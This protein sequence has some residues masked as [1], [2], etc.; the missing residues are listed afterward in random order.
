MCSASAAPGA[1]TK[2]HAASSR[3]RT[4]GITSRANRRIERSASAREMVLKFTCSDA[5][6]NPPTSSLNAR[7]R[8]ASSRGV[9]IQ[10]TPFA[11]CVSKVSLASAAMIL[12]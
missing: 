2:R 8:C 12:S 1:A 4:A 3:P 9:P 10:A 7:M 5:L 6:S 11:V